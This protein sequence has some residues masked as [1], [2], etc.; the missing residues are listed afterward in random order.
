VADGE[1]FEFEIAPDEIGENKRAK[2]SDV[3][4]VMH[5]RAAAIKTDIFSGWI[6]RDKFLHG[7]RERVEK[8]QGHIFVVEIKVGPG[9]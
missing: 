1:A 7:T 4:E 8:F 2:I 3:R 6:E 5:G 9:K